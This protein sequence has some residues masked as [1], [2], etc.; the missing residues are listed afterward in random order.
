MRQA[1]L[2]PDLPASVFP[3]AS[4]VENNANMSRLNTAKP[5]T[6]TYRGGQN[7]AAQAVGSAHRGS[8]EFADDM[9]N[10]GDFL[11]VGELLN[12]SHHFTVLS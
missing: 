10:D 9:L 2:K 6:E 1:E 12:D 4:E 11:A 3:V 8:D 7:V 5:A